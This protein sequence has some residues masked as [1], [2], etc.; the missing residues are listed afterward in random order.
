[1]C[2]DMHTNLSSKKLSQY[3][4]VHLHYI[5]LLFLLFLPQT[6]L[7]SVIGTAAATSFSDDLHRWQKQLQTIEAVLGVWLQVQALWVQLEV[8]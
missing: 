5:S 4:V 3:H 2:T 7:Q 1:M 6:S 8:S